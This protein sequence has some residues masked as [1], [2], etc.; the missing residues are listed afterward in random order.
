MNFKKFIAMGTLI[1]LTV[2]SNGVP[3]FATEQATGKEYNESVKQEYIDKQANT[4]TLSL[5]EAVEYALENSKDIIIQNIEL[6][7]AELAYKQGIKDAKNNERIIDDIPTGEI[8][9][10]SRELI[11][12]GVPR[13]SVEL[14]YQVAQWN[15]KIKENQIKYN[16]EKSYF[17]LSQVKKE[18]EIAEENLNLTQKQYNSGK[19]KYDVG[20]I[21]EQELLGLEMGLSKAQTAY[22][23]AKVYYDLQLMNFQNTSGLTFDKEVVL[24]DSIE[25]KEYEPINIKESIKQA[26]ENNTMVKIGQESYELSE[27]TFDAIKI[28]YPD[29]TYKYKEQE[30]EVAKAAKNLE[31]VKNGVEMGV[32]A[33]YLNLLTAEKQIKT[34]EKNIEQAER[35]ARLA[36]VSLDLGQGTSIEVLQANLNLM[37]AKKDLSSQIHAF[38][39]AL[40]DYEYSIGIGKT[41]ISGM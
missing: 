21:S 9:S 30:A 5:E 1:T 8:D 34:L 12:T 18:V 4:I 13:R 7:K 39:M 6:E 36:E 29:I 27:L 31:T 20:I 41:P 35:M 40:L 37:S 33:A 14:T 17:D 16:V 28:K 2:V 15:L 23:S 38:N 26:I 19:L 32:R 10:V 11:D 24:I 25:Y 22:D 3:T